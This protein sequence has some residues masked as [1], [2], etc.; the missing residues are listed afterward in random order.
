MNN[1]DKFY[2]LTY[3]LLSPFHIGLNQRSFSNMTR[4]YMPGFTISG[5]IIKNYCIFKQYNINEFIEKNLENIFFSSFFIKKDNKIFY[6][7]VS[8][9]KIGDIS[10]NE[11]EPNFIEIRQ[12][13]SIDPEKLNAKE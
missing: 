3:K 7:N 2:K 10:Y 6:P 1:L 12:S 11:F 5:A 13:T 8:S 4:C 9:K